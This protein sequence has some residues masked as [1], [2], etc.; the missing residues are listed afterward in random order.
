MTDVT[1][2]AQGVVDHE[3]RWKD[4]K[5]A[6]KG[7]ATNLNIRLHEGRAQAPD[8][9]MRSVSVELSVK[10]ARLLMETL[11]VLLKEMSQ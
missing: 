11:K 6:L 4:P 1:I 8:Q 10:Q 5:I 7:L 2:A 9:I 3:R